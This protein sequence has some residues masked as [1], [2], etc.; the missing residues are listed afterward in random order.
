MKIEVSSK[1]NLPKN[2]YRIS[3]ISS[4]NMKCIYCHNEG[5]KKKS[6]LSIE[7]IKKIIKNSYG[8][9]MSKVRLTGGEPLIHPQIFDIC[10]MLSEKYNLKV[11][12]NTNC[13]E[14]DKLLFMIKK[15]W[16]DRVVVGL[17]YFDNNISKQSPIGKSSKEILNNVL[18]IKNN[19]CD[20]S[21]STVYNGDYNNI[22]NLVNWC[23]NN[24]IRIKIIEL[25]KNEIHELS[26]ENFIKMRDNI[27]NDFK[28]KVSIDEFEEYN[29]YIG[30][31][32]IVSFFPSLCRLRRCDLCKKIHLRITSE[33]YIKQ[34][35]H[36]SENDKYI[37]GNMIRENIIKEIESEVDYHEK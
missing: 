19:N 1:R 13:V 15:G 2:E 20:V 31:N 26:D 28:F 4:C 36:Y 9:G 29:G 8:L 3:I 25:I 18:K 32:R 34:C 21:I 7:D 17:D 11:G 23:K 10:K 5:N 14:I 30:K 33:G 22:Y 27:I 16:I 12:I 37:L 24:N 35:I 6:M